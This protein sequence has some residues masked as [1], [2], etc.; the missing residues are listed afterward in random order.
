MLNLAALD[1]R[2]WLEEGLWPPCSSSGNRG[3]LPLAH[4]LGSLFPEGTLQRSGKLCATLSL[5]LSK[6][7]QSLEG[8][9]VREIQQEEVPGKMPRL[10]EDAPPPKRCPASR[11][12]RE[13]KHKYLRPGHVRM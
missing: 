10:Q 9:H 8:Q 3:R 1:V 13:T 5:S 6:K 2:V 7:P 11:K 4:T 12:Y